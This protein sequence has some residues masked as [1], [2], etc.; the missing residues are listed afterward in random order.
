MNEVKTLGIEFLAPTNSFHGISFSSLEV[1][2]FHGM[3]VGRDC[4]LAVVTSDND[5]FATSF[6]HLRETSNESCPKLNEV[7]IDLI[8]SLRVLRIEEVSKEL[9]RILVITLNIE[10]HQP[11]V[12]HPQ[13]Q[14]FR[15]RTFVIYSFGNTSDAIKINVSYA[16]PHVNGPMPYFT[17]RLNIKVN[18]MKVSPASGLTESSGMFGR[19]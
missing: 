17:T 8:P 5:K 7:S 4:Q 15:R 11:Y 13:I 19:M 14:N 2:Q 1:L 9:S 12:H 6:S 3:Q 16:P 18:S 10:E